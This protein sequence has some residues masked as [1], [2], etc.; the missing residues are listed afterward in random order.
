VLAGRETVK[1]AT[2]E[3]SA[4]DGIV[5]KEM[6]PSTVASVELWGVNTMQYT[7][8][9]MVMNS[10]NHWDGNATGNRHT[11]FILEG[12]LQAGEVRGFYNEFLS[13]E[14]NDHRKVF[15]MLGTRMRV[16]ASDNQLSGLGFSSTQR[17]HV[18]CKV[19][20]SF[21]RIIKITF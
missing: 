9:A 19:T 8:V 14:L 17:N 3:Y 5:F 13:S 12:C 20:G 21:N 1:V 6:L 18:F 10:P 16:A 7:K 2:I 4:T 11:F 15:E